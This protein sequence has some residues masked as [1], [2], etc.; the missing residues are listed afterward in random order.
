MSAPGYLDGLLARAKGE[1]RELRP[2]TAPYFAPEGHAMDIP[3]PDFHLVRSAPGE[4]APK[5][6]KRTSDKIAPEIGQVGAARLMPPKSA[7]I[8]PSIATDPPRSAPA[9]LPQSPLERAG[10]PEPEA[11]RLARAPV[12]EPRSEKTMRSTERGSPPDPARARDRPA[13]P[14][15]TAE[16]ARVLARLAAGEMTAASPPP[17]PAETRR[18]ESGSEPRLMP[19]AAPAPRPLPDMHTEP[20]S[21]TEE[22]FVIHIGEIHIAPDPVPSAAPLAAMPRAERPKWQPALSLGEYRSQRQRGE[23]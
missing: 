11:A 17:P 1:I 3:E 13:P 22:T 15:P 2:K 18:M 23:R 16:L 19:P 10:P 4:P 21:E 9:P 14:D 12:P 7:E 20:P 8:A 6:R 5:A